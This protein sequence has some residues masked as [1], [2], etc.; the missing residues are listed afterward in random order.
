[1]DETKE[2]RKLAYKD[3]CEGSARLRSHDFSDEAWSKYRMRT[4]QVWPYDRFP[5]ITRWNGQDLKD[6]TILLWYEQGVGEQLLFAQFASRMAKEA[7]RVVFECDKRIVSLLQRSMPDVEVVPYTVPWDDKVYEADYQCPAGDVLTYKISSWKDFT[8]S[9][10]FLKP[11]PLKVEYFKNKYRDYDK[12]VGINW[13][14]S[15]QFWADTKSCPVKKF[16][17][18]YTKVPC[19]SLQY[20][21]HYCP[22][23]VDDEVNVFNDFESTA[24]LS[25]VCTD[26]I[27]VSNATAHLIGGLGLKNYVLLT[28]TSG[29]HWYWFPECRP[30]PFYVNTEVVIQ[31]IPYFWDN[32]VSYITNK[33]L[34]KQ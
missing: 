7:G 20:G 18:L 14:S 17:K 4:Y 13:A 24:A 26:I 33:I 25:T 1:M 2:L 34:D 28:Q 32:K 15:A 30:H 5:G 8:F 31:N 3:M 12:L 6:K 23:K 9:N 10:G 11:D 22:F 27:N 16:K 21:Q 29:R 19:I